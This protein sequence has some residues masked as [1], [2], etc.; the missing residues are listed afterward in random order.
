MASML[1]DKESARAHG[2][3]HFDITLK[4]PYLRSK[5]YADGVVSA[6]D[7]MTPREIVYL[8]Y[9]SFSPEWNPYAANWYHLD[10]FKHANANTLRRARLMFAVRYHALKD[11]VTSMPK[12]V[13]HSVSAEWKSTIRDETT[14]AT[15]AMV[16][17]RP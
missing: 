7:D 8:W 1:S 16:P 6:L 12:D 17:A 15:R 14:A 3:R 10:G 9:G 11:K 5:G 2:F 4:M 13:L